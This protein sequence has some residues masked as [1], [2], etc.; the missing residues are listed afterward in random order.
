MT[1][2][3]DSVLFL[4]SAI[5]SNTLQYSLRPYLPSPL[6]RAHPASQERSDHESI[7]FQLTIHD[8]TKFS[9][10]QLPHAKQFSYCSSKY[11][12]WFCDGI[13]N[14]RFEWGY[15]SMLFHNMLPSLLGKAN[16]DTVP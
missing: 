12:Y 13:H 6:Q 2:A 15:F 10:L 1:K 5:I 9:Q 4:A 8:D 3:D 7:A 14:F 16:C 11:A